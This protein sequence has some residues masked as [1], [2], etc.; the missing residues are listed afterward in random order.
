MPMTPL[1]SVQAAVQRLQELEKKLQREE[2]LTLGELRALMQL[3]L[4]LHA[5]RG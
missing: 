1:T 3:P 2:N 4:L 5:L